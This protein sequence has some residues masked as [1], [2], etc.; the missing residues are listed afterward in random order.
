MKIINTKGHES[1]E[2]RVLI[3]TWK[4]EDRERSFRNLKE[5]WFLMASCK[6][7]HEMGSQKKKKRHFEQL[8]S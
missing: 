4:P 1:D 5:R 3:T 7:H 6:R 8:K 2:I